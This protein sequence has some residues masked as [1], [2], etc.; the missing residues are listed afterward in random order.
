MKNGNFEFPLPSKENTKTNWACLRCWLKPG[1]GE[2]SVITHTSGKDNV[3]WSTTQVSN[4]GMS[5]IQI[6]LDKKMDNYS[7]SYTFNV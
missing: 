3:I 2:R 7:V 1:A 6:P 4:G 5:Y